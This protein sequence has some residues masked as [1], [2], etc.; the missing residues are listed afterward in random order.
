VSNEQS[1]GVPGWD[2]PPQPPTVDPFPNNLGS[3][4]PPRPTGRAGRPSSPPAGGASSPSTSS[5]GSSPDEPPAPGRAPGAGGNE[6]SARLADVAAYLLKTGSNLASV[7]TKKRWGLNL[8]M[9]D[10]EAL[11]LARPLARI[12]ERRFH[13]RG[14]LN[15]AADAAEGAGNLTSW[16]TRLAFELPGR[17]P[18]P[19]RVDY[20][21]APVPQYPAGTVPLVAE[22]RPAPAQPV[23]MRPPAPAAP[24]APAPPQYLDRDGRPVPGS[25]WAKTAFLDG[26]DE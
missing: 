14:D 17:P 1:Q 22:P 20:A 19:P 21:P 7:L 18:P 13:V 5:Q 9:Q 6:G 10:G 11:A 8:G 3:Q 12:V 15:D 2:V 23:Y 25:G 16:L 24:A 26:F 4:P